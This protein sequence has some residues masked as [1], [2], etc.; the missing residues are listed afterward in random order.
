MY[1]TPPCPN[2]AASIAG[3]PPWS[4]VLLQ[5]A[6]QPLHHPFDARCVRVHEALLD[7][8]PKARCLLSYRKKTGKL[9]R[10]CSLAWI[11]ESFEVLNVEADRIVRVR[12]AFEAKGWTRNRNRA[13]I[14]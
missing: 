6:K 8:D 2:F 10:D 4:V 13:G 14:A 7:A 5:R 12:F 11:A 1:S 3:V 9:Y